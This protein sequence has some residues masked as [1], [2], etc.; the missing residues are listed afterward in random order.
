MA[1]VNRNAMIA[2]VNWLSKKH[3]YE[4]VYKSKD[5]SFI[6]LKDNHKELVGYRLP[7]SDEWE[8]AARGEENDKPTFFFGSNH[9]IEVGWYSKNS[10]EI[11][12]SK[13]YGNYGTILVG[14]KWPNE[15]CIYDMLG[16]VWE[17]TGLL[18]F[19]WLY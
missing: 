2:Y 16:N 9:L 8:Y 12:S 3:R 14:S 1:G 13:I 19:F 15:L 6:S 7:S 4:S 5:S 18:I 17:Y 10:N 11:S